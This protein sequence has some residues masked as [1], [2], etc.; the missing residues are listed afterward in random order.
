MTR[1]KFNVFGQIMSV[2]LEHDTWV[3]YRESQ[4]GI[5]AKIYDVVIPSDL[6]EEDLVTYLD[7]IYHEMASVKFPRVLKL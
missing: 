3:L 2:T 6:K 7:D 5:R 1:L 4:V